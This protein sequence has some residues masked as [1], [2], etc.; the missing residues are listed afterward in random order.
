MSKQKISMAEL[1]KQFKSKIK[2]SVLEVPVDGPVVKPI[3]EIID[4]EP[5]AQSEIETEPVEQVYKRKNKGR[6][7]SKRNSDTVL[8]EQE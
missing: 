2:H 6:H 8:I 7:K 3:D 4:T 5:L 1:V